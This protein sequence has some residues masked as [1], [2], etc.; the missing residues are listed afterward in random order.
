MTRENKIKLLEFQKSTTKA[1]EN[2]LK[3]MYNH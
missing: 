3:R 2:E 1:L